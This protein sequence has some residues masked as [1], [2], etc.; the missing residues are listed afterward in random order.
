MGTRAASIHTRG[1]A[2]GAPSHARVPHQGSLGALVDLPRHEAQVQN[3]GDPPVPLASSN[4]ELPQDHGLSLV[5]PTTGEVVSS[6]DPAG[7]LRVLTEVRELE[8]RLRELKAGLTDAI[9]NEC[10]RQGTKTLELNGYKA[11]LRGGSEIVWD[12]EL[13][14]GLRDLGLPEERMSALITTEVTYR[15][16]ANE[17]KRIASVNPEYAEVI[18]RAKSIIPKAVYVSLKR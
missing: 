3:Q 12:V 15:V 8:A 18:E 2:G 14:E 17:A 11:E 10:S 7:C 6:D 16:N 4:R 13:L 9:A 1:F 5:V